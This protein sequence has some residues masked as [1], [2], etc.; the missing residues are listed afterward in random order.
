MKGSIIRKLA[1]MTLVMALTWLTVAPAAFADDPKPDAPAAPAA[2][3][4]A[5]AAAPADAAAPAADAAP[6]APTPPQLPDSTA[7]GAN[8]GTGIDLQW[9]AIPAKT[10]PKTGLTTGEPTIDDAGKTTAGANSELVKAVAHNKIS[11][12]IVWT[13]VTGFLVMFMQA[14]FA[15]VE[16]GLC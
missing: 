5:P 13:L 7:T 6:A 1:S 2:A 3:D 12:N 8:G 4:T 14:G 11:I 16:T 10:D 9:P 15:L